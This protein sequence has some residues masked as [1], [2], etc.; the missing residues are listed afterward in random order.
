MGTITQA[1]IEKAYHLAK[2]VNRLKKSES[3]AVSELQNI[4]MNPASAQMYIENFSHM[5]AG[6]CFKRT[7][8]QASFR[9]YLQ[10]ICEEFG[11]ATLRKALKATFEHFQYYES[12]GRGR[13]AGVESIA[14]EFSRRLQLQA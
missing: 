7:M 8:N 13:L 4:G 6:K 11:D 1:M 2:D 3:V 14:K 9:Y 10:N 12:H 5:M